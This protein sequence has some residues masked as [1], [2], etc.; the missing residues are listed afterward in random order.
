MRALHFNKETAANGWV[1]LQNYYLQ[2]LDNC[3]NRPLFRMNGYKYWI[4]DRYF[5]FEL[6]LLPCKAGD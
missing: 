6:G 2:N 3:T 1:K 5:S 4:N